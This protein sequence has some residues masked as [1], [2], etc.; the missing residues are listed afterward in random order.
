MAFLMPMD[1]EK[2]KYSGKKEAVLQVNPD[3][4]DVSSGVEK[5]TGEGKDR[6]KTEKFLAKIRLILKERAGEKLWIKKITDIMEN[7]VDSMF[8]NHL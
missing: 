1:N 4:V 3:V 2:I 8:L 5:D 7:L 6:E